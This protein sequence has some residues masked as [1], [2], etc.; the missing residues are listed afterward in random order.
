MGKRQKIQRPTNKSHYCSD[1]QNIT[2]THEC[3]LCKCTET[4]LM[5]RI[6]CKNWQS[7]L[8]RFNITSRLCTRKKTNE[9]IWWLITLFIKGFADATR[10]IEERCQL[11]ALAELLCRLRACSITQPQCHMPQLPMKNAKNLVFLTIYLGCLLGLK[12]MKIWK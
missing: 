12:I 10:Q 8:S 3:Y 2:I 1:R 9:C 7:Y 4:C 5:V 6:R 11:F